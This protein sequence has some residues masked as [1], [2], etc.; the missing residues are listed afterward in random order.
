M[1]PA[2]DEQAR[3]RVKLRAICDSLGYGGQSKLARMIGRSPKTIRNKLAGKSP[4]AQSDELAIRQA[5]VSR[6]ADSGTNACNS[7][8]CE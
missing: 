2:D 5:L 1:T 3:L 6:P 7:A 4:I 8:T